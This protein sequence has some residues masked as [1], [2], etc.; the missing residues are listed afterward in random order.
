MDRRSALTL[1]GATVAA[2]S[3]LRG[4]AAADTTLG[5]DPHV[6]CMEKCTTCHELCEQTFAWTLSADRKDAERK[7]LAPLTR[8]LADCAQFCAMSASLMARKS[9]LMIHSCRACAEAC[10]ECLAGCEKVKDPQ[11][12]KCADACRE[13]EKSCREMVELMESGEHQHA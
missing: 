5:K 11:T 7:E 4:I 1:L 13:C 12:A 6:D 8:L 2:S 9:P 3:T 10:K